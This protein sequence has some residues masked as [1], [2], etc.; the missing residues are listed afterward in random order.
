MSQENNKRPANERIASVSKKLRYE[1][2]EEIHTQETEE[3]HPQETDICEVCRT[4][5]YD[6]EEVETESEEE[7]EEECELDE[8]EMED[9]HGSSIGEE[10]GKLLHS[11]RKSFPEENID[12]L[13]EVLA[14]RYGLQMYIEEENVDFENKLLHENEINDAKVLLIH[15]FQQL[16]TIAQAYFTTLREEIN[17]YQEE[18]VVEAYIPLVNRILRKALRLK[19]RVD[20]LPSY[21]ARVELYTVAHQV[22]SRLK[23]MTADTSYVFAECFHY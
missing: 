7:Y 3:E 6:S 12:T 11:F 23:T 9:A 1:E 18:G 5:S 4:L 8:V 20:R 15:G 16:S 21:Q 10:D 13:R 22:P 2:E 17:E 19:Q 14:R